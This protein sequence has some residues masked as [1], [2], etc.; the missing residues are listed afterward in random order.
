MFP[1]TYL[2]FFRLI[3]LAHRLDNDGQLSRFF[4]SNFARDSIS[5]GSPECVVELYEAYLTI[6]KMLRDPANVIEYKMIPGDMVTINNHRVLHG[7]TEF[8][9]T[10]GGSRFLAGIYMDW[11]TMYSRLRVL[12]R[13]LNLPCP[14]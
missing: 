12:A 6:G 11:D 1:S 7:R 2:F 13:K 9:V 8:T 14:C 4:L 10:E 3:F 5:K